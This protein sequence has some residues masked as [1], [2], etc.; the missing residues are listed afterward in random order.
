MPE[1]DFTKIQN[2]FK[3]FSPGTEISERTINPGSRS[4]IIEQ[5]QNIL[6]N[7]SGGV[8]SVENLKL[9]LEG[10]YKDATEDEH[11]ELNRYFSFYSTLGNLSPSQ[12]N[13]NAATSALPKGAY[14]WTSENGNK[15]DN[16]IK[17]LELIKNPS[18]HSKIHGLVRTLKRN[19]KTGQ[20]TL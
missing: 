20:F 8:F 16:R 18:I 17:N 1:E 14:Y 2:I 9:H 15:K 13:R 11:R 10:L 6:I 7:T 3:M 5:L 4:K 12:E 19:K